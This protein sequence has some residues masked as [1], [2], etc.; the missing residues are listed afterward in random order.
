MICVNMLFIST[1]QHFHVDEVAI[2]WTEGKHFK[3]IPTVALTHYQHILYSNSKVALFVVT[4][5]V[6]DY[7]TLFQDSL[8]EVANTDRT[9]MHA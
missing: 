5:F 6:C 8:A 2:I 3:I 9:L 4:W 1:G 7:H